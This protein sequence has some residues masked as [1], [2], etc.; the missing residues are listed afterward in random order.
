MVTSGRCRHYTVEY[1]VF[2][3]E[4]L[5]IGGLL[6][7]GEEG[8]NSFDFAIYKVRLVGHSRSSKS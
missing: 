4:T 8:W 5:G 2:I 7:I 1:F 3:T 6:Y